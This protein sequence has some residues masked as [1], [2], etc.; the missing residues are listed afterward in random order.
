MKRAWPLA[1]VLALTALAGPAQGQRLESTGVLFA[2]GSGKVV[3]EA[4]I[5]V[6]AR[7]DLVVSYHGDTAAGC[8]AYGL[9]AYSGSIVVRPRT[10]EVDVVTIRQQRRL[11][12]IVLFSLGAGAGPG[13]NPSARVQRS[14]PG[15]PATTCADAPGSVLGGLANAVTHGRSVTIRLLEPGGSFLQT[16]CAGPLD[17]DLAA[18]SPAVTIPI[19]RLLRGRMSLALGGMRTFSVHGFSGTVSSTLT[20]KLDKPR[21][22]SSSATPSPGGKPHRVRVVTEHLSLA[23]ISGELGA[24]V[25]GT[26]NPVVCAVLDT[27]GLTGTLSFRSVPHDASAE[28]VA[29]GSARRPYRDF[30]TALGLSRSGRAHG[31]MVSLQAVSSGD[32]RTSVSQPGGTCTDTATTGGVSFSSGSGSGASGGFFGTWRTRCP[33]P[34]LGLGALALRGSFDRAALG[35]TQF[36]IG[37]RS[38]GSFA[39]DGYAVTPHGRLSILL[40]R[41]RITQ[42]V[43]SE[44]TG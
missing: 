7:G 8:A 22:E 27:C 44:P 37:L 29:F 9:C 25:R 13:Y 38:T 34:I 24:A 2:F 40:R 5:P 33:G 1:V 6:Q 18:A 4:S 41:G 10:G 16:R 28:V 43:V 21:S 42:Q 12:H 19:A 23:R 31:I 15:E 3:A 17:G 36:T 14:L 26:S 39:D 35:H 11:R 30:L 20:M 32:V